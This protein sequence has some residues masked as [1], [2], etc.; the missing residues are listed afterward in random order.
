MTSRAPITIVHLLTPFVSEQN[1]HELSSTTTN[2]YVMQ[3]NSQHP[4]PIIRKVRL[5]FFFS[6][7]VTC[8]GELIIL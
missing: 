5:S 1:S 2:R 7:I 8:S 6:K 3:C 4:W